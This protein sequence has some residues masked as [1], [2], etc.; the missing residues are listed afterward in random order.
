MN[1][2][3][4]SSSLGENKSYKK[5]IISKSIVILNILLVHGCMVLWRPQLKSKV[6]IMLQ[7]G[8]PNFQVCQALESGGVNMVVGF[9]EVSSDWQELL[10]CKHAVTSVIRVHGVM[11]ILGINEFWYCDIVNLDVEW[12]HWILIYLHLNIGKFIFFFLQRFCYHCCWWCNVN[13][14]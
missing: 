9:N 3:S 7:K 2:I 14:L 5:V 12:L 6:W 13:F 10:L 1:L 11:W 4:W 8:K